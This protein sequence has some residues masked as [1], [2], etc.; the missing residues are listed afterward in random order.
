MITNK[1]SSDYLFPDGLIKHR[2]FDDQPNGCYAVFDEHKKNKCL[3]YIKDNKLTNY[4]E[5]FKDLPNIPYIVW[6]FEYDDNMSVYREFPSNNIQKHLWYNKNGINPE[7]KEQM[8]RKDIIW[9]K[10][11]SEA[12]N[13][14]MQLEGKV[15]NISYC[16]NC[17]KIEINCKDNSKV[18][19]CNCEQN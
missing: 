6:S 13:K 1:I 17:N 19:Y 2:Y 7:I 12:L 15:D 16:K 4:E 9:D 5:Y 3:A 14:S 11:V 8:E 10:M 18:K